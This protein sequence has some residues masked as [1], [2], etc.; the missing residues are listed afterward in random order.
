MQTI[1]KINLPQ[2]NCTTEIITTFRNMK[3]VKLYSNKNQ[4]TKSSKSSKL[5]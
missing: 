5:N 3:R 2:H 4:H 1:L